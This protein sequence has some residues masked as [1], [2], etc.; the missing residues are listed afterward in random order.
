VDLSQQ[1]IADMQERLRQLTQAHVPVL[2]AMQHIEN[3]LSQPIS[4]AELAKLCYLSEDYFIRRFRECVGQSP[5]QYIRE[6]RVTM[7]AQ[8]LLFS[9][10]SIDDIA[11]ATGF[12]NRLLFF[13]CLRAPDGRFTRCVSQDFARVNPVASTRR[14]LTR[15]SRSW[16]R[17]RAAAGRCPAPHR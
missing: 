14:C 1:R 8:Q 3:N 5:S 11:T 4:N 16:S 7:A 15:P 13:A 10:A 2:P 9:G 17:L 12:G 6:R